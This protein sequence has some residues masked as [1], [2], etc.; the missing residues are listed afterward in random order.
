MNTPVAILVR[1]STLKQDTDRQIHELQA[2]AAR[3]QWDVVEVIEEQGVSRK[4]ALHQRPGLHRAMEL[5]AEGFIRKILVHEVSRVGRPAVVYPFV[6]ELHRHKVSLYWHAQQVETLLPDGRRSQAAGLMLALMSEMA[7]AEV[8]T[9]SERVKSGLLEARRKGVRLG[10][11]VGS[12]DP[13]TIL[14]RHPDIVALV[15]NNKSLRDIAARTGKSQTT[16]LKVRRL[17]STPAA[18]VSD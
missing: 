15:R 4:A 18:G 3:N 6:E 1:V 9:L 14:A 8:E 10:R 2:L 12:E 7:H 17:L 11:P 5:A 16:V 13:A